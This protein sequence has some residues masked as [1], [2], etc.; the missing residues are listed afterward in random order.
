MRIPLHLTMGRILC[1]HLSPFLDNGHSPFFAPSIRC[2][3]RHRSI[4]HLVFAPRA[5]TNTST[6][7]ITYSSCSRNS[8]R[9]LIIY[10]VVSDARRTHLWKAQARLVLF[11]SVVASIQSAMLNTSQAPR[12]RSRGSLFRLLLRSQ[13]MADQHSLPQH[14]VLFP[15]VYDASPFRSF[16]FSLLYHGLSP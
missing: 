15:R 12:A 3:T 6:A 16:F 2:W 8:P 7:Y 10:R 5:I 14:K 9:Y 13:F 11:G 4:A 1:G